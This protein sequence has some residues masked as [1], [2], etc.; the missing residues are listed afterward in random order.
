[1]TRQKDKKITLPKFW[2]FDYS[3][4]QEIEQQVL[5]NTQEK[6]FRG[7]TLK[8]NTINRWIQKKMEIQKR[9]VGKNN[10]QFDKPL[11]LIQ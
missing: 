11:D 9:K 10:G 3:Q 2:K 6:I 7:K 4:L 5:E 8:M 1:M